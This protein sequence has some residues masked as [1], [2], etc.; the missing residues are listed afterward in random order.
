MI[1]SLYDRFE[2]RIRERNGRVSNKNWSGKQRREKMLASIFVHEKERKVFKCDS[3]VSPLENECEDEV[4][5]R[6]K[7]AELCDQKLETN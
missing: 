4:K 3:Y 1:L 7:R 5:R 6:H 2:R